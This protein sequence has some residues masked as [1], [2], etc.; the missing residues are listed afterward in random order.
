MSD[1]IG[2]G[3]SAVSK[4]LFIVGS[5]AFAVALVYLI[6]AT[7]HVRPGVSQWADAPLLNPLLLLL[8][9]T[10][11]TK[12][13]LTY[14]RRAGLAL[15]LFM[16]AWLVGIGLDSAASRLTSRFSGP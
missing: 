6:K 3:I 10:N 14:R 15:G 16:L 9:A 12:V 13:G 11:L 4:G 8:A 7:A 5:L 1:V 2:T